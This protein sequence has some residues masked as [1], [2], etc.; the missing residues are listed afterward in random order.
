M[1]RDLFELFATVSRASDAQ[2]ITGYFFAVASS[3]LLYMELFLSSPSGQHCPATRPNQILAA[4]CPAQ[5]LS[6][7]N[8]RAG[9]RIQDFNCGAD[10]PRDGSAALGHKLNLPLNMQRSVTW[11]SMSSE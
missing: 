5:S 11:Y 1:P 7:S 10:D 9:L 4:S 6:D 3:H 8:H 2:L